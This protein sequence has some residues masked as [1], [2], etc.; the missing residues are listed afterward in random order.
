MT[1][2]AI[3]NTLSGRVHLDSGRRQSWRGG[4][5]AFAACGREVEHW[6]PTR[7]EQAMKVRRCKACAKRA[8]IEGAGQQGSI[9]KGQA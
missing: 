8:P 3:R 5:V 9:E 2:P 1:T 7:W 6:E 4:R